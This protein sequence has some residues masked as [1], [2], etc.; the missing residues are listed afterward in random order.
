MEVVCTYHRKDADVR[1]HNAALLEQ[2]RKANFESIDYIDQ[3]NINKAPNLT[4][5]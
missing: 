2:R 5:V 3:A 4:F 1:H